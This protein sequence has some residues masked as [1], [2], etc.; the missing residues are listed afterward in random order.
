MVYNAVSTALSLLMA[1]GVISVL[2]MGFAAFSI[3][4]VAPI[5]I[6]VRKTITSHE[7]LRIRIANAT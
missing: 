7:T 6:K 5:Y 4:F 1:G 3:G 2:L